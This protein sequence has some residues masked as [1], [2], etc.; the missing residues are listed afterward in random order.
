MADI[1]A[2]SSA[3]DQVDDDGCGHGPDNRDDPTD[4][5]VRDSIEPRVDLGAETVY[6]ATQFLHVLSHL[7]SEAVIILTHLGSEA[8]IILS[9]LG[10]ETPDLFLELP[11]LD[12]GILALF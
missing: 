8:A 9:H 12:V 3:V 4:H 1:P 5:D 6:L 10:S 7:G 11:E 2:L